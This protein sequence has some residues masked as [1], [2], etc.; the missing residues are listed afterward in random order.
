M[1]DESDNPTKQMSGQDDTFH[2]APRRVPLNSL[3][4]SSRCRRSM[5]IKPCEYDA[6]GS[7]GK[8]PTGASR[9]SEGGWFQ[10]GWLH[11]IWKWNKS[12]CA[13][14]CGIMMGWMGKTTSQ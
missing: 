14:E 12:I 2:A 4:G 7:P 13:W 5:S 6:I 8:S 11:V 10:D 3:H 1:R 9:T